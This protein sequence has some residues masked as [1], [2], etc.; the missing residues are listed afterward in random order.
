VH[1]EVI[2]ILS[3]VFGVL[4]SAEHGCKRGRMASMNW[5]DRDCQR[6]SQ[7]GG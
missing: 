6:A 7:R 4:P 3:R 1:R 2:V 5:A